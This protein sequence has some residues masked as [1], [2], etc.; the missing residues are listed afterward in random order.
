MK[1]ASIQTGFNDVKDV[2][3]FWW[4]IMIALAQREEKD[5]TA[6][7]KC[8]FDVLAHIQELRDQIE[9]PN[10]VNEQNCLY[11]LLPSEVEIDW[12]GCYLAAK[13]EGKF[14]TGCDILGAEVST[15]KHTPSQGKGTSSSGSGGSG[16]GRGRG[17]ES[18][19]PD[20]QMQLQE[21]KEIILDSAGTPSSK[22]GLYLKEEGKS[23]IGEE[24]EDD[25]DDDDDDDEE[26][27]NNANSCIQHCARESPSPPQ[28]HLRLPTTV[29]H[30]PKQTAYKTRGKRLSTSFLRDNTDVDIED[31]NEEDEGEC[32]GRSEQQVMVSPVTKSN[33]MW[34]TS[35]PDDDGSGG[36]DNAYDEEDYEQQNKKPKKG[37]PS[38]KRS[39][40]SGSS[41]AGG[42]KKSQALT[43]RQKLAQ[44]L[45]KGKKR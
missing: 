33:E 32:G 26:S 29:Q 4:D 20:Q 5:Q 8:R 36:S 37:G 17:A 16:G 27:P 40:N 1:E 23:P 38:S 6:E 41:C 28:T 15:P 31:R 3:K 39:P 14:R 42:K 18:K 19:S 7:Q 30:Q 35:F 34:N 13:K 24:V 25:D 11:A 44:Q 22:D 12:E 10:F 45:K 9:M 2:V 21:Q 43:I